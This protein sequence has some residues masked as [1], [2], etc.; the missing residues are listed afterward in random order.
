MGTANF[1]SSRLT[2]VR[3]NRTIANY[4]QTLASQFESGSATATY[5]VRQ[6]QQPNTTGNIIAYKNEAPCA[7]NQVDYRR[8]L[9]QICCGAATQ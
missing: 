8:S 3:R 5:S 7:C 2:Q 1:D 9:G 6:I 4:A